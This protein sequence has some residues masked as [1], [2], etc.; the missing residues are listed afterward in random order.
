MSH[1]AHC[2][3]ALA[4][5][6]T[7]LEAV[8]FTAPLPSYVVI[9]LVLLWLWVEGLSCVCDASVGFVNAHFPIS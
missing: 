7:P 5:L 4:V 6:S 9:V 2:D 3:S 8:G 1:L